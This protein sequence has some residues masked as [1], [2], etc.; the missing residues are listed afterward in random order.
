MRDVTWNR[1]D[2]SRHLGKKKMGYTQVFPMTLIKVL[3]DSRCSC[4]R[5]DSTTLKGT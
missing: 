5:K 1:T 3:F 4:A 2:Y